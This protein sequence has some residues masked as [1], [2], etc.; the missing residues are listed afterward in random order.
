[1]TEIL[2]VVGIAPPTPLHIVAHNPPHQ[3]PFGPSRE[4]VV[5]GRMKAEAVVLT[6]EV[7]EIQTEEN[8]DELMIHD[9]RI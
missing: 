9:P 2:L 7:V 8:E 6:V 4:K 5:F 3:E 1:M